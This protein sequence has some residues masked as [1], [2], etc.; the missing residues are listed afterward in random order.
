MQLDW[1]E[2]IGQGRRSRVRGS[3]VTGQW[4]VVNGQWSMV[5]GQWSMVNGQL[6]MVKI[7]S[8]VNDMYR[9]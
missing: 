1:S 8:L 3:T 6:A 2:V 4:S 5:N 9:I 7:N